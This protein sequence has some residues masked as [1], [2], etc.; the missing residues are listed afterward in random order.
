MRM[1]S[2]KHRRY[3]IFFFLIPFIV[4]AC[5][6]DSNVPQSELPSPPSSHAAVGTLRGSIVF[7]SNRDGDWEI[8]AMNADGSRLVQL[9]QNTAVDKLPAWSPD[10]REIAFTSNREGN[11]EVYVMQADGSQPRNITHHPALDEAPAWSPD[12]KQIA[13]HSDRHGK[14]DIFIM[15]KN[16]S[17]VQQITNAPGR[18]VL[19]AWSPQGNW[20]AYTSNREGEWN[21][22]FRQCTDAQTERRVAA[23]CRPA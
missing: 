20:L 11:F 9:T 18:N 12:G 23:G 1:S 17:Y 16:G 7:Q 4:L 15:Q 10:G 13:F 3:K 21:V 8:Y 2:T 19:P 22:Y 5:R 14:M 6:Q